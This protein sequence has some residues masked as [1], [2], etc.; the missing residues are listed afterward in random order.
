LSR[1]FELLERASKD[2][3]SFSP[4][5]RGIASVKEIRPEPDAHSLPREELMKL[6]QRVFLLNHSER[7]V[8]VF[9][10]V[11]SG[12]GCTSICGGAGG[13]LDA[14]VDG[15]VC[16]VDANL[17]RP[18]LHSCFGTENLKGLTDAVFKPGPIREF[19]QKLPGGNLWLLPCGSMTSRLS[20]TIK[21]EQL[22]ARI[23][24]L[25]KEFAYVLID[26]P[27]VNE[28]P[29]AI[30]LGKLTDGVVLVLESNVT[31]RQVARIVKEDFESAK[32]RLLGVVLNKRT[33]PIP[34]FLYDRL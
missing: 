15:P 26:S 16:L 24:E 27:A 5:R 10:S 12:A 22:Q 13:V 17:R 33:F 31:R 7:R 28:Y 18:A 8:V 4:F 29:D 1:N 23:S 30:L 19:V 2:I 25:S 32:V 9:T 21:A 20:T 34:Q 6:V 3:D 11:E 14:Q